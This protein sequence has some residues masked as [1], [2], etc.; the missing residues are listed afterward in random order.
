M[1]RSEIGNQ[2]RIE[3]NHPPERYGGGT[4]VLLCAPHHTSNQHGSQ[5]RSNNIPSVPLLHGTAPAAV[6]CEE[7]AHHRH[8]SDCEATSAVHI[9]DLQ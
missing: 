6:G 8:C 7:A 4:R 1:Y 9:V 5:R 3:T 2:Q